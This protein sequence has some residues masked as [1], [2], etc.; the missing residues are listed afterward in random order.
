[1]PLKKYGSIK[2][3]RPDLLV[4]WNYQENSCS[5]DDI[6]IGNG[7]LKIDWKCHVCGFEW[8][9]T[10][11]NRAHLHSGCPECA[12]Q[13]I[14]IKN[15]NKNVSKDNN[16]KLLY[17]EIAAEWCIDKNEGIKPEHVAP[18]S[19][20][21][22]WWHCSVCGTE[23]QTSVTNRTGY[24]HVGCPKC[25]R[26]LHTSF[27]EQSLFYY[28]S[29]VYSDAVS[30]YDGIGMELDVFIPSIM[31]GVE[32]D[33][34]HWHSSKQSE[35][36]ENKKY[37]LC[38]DKNIELIR[39]REKKNNENCSKKNCDC[40]VQRLNNSDE[41]LEKTICEVLKILK[42][43]YRADVDLTRDRGI[44][45]NNYIV[46][47]KENS[48]YSKFPKIAAEWNDELNGEL[49]PSMVAAA[50]NTKVWWICPK[51][52]MAYKTSPADRTGTNK[53]GCPYCAGK[54]IAPGLNDLATKY[55]EIAAD[56]DFLKNKNLKPNEIAPNYIKKVWWKCSICGTEY[57]L[58]PNKRVSRQ[59]G[60]PKCAR[61]LKI[62]RSRMNSLDNGQNSLSARYP[63]I[64]EDWDYDE[65]D[66]SPDQITPGNDRKVYWKCHVCGHVWL[67]SPYSR[68]HLKSGCP[69]CANKRNGEKTHKKH[70][71]NG[72]NSLQTCRPDL[73]LDWNFSKNT[74]SPRN[75]SLGNNEKVMWK[76]HKCGNEW[77]TSVYNRA[78][79]NSQCPKC[80][81]NEM[82]LQK[83]KKMIDSGNTL[84]VK[85]PTIAA[86]WHPSRNGDLTPDKIA[87]HSHAKV[88]WKCPICGN[89]W[90]TSVCNRT[91]EKH[92]GCRKCSRRKSYVK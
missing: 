32:Y 88:W 21:K 24:K 37:K 44:I 68:I 4:D 70:L 67:A 29:K 87:P 61:L 60:C 56:W 30:G 38:K 42:K 50:T 59:Q 63:E 83:Q 75:I 39:V 73:M 33:G 65:N 79:L 69:Q 71:N 2:N 66:I 76:C 14:S 86:E 57:F 48:L 3:E 64:L 40:L 55:P 23:Y 16:L 19:N 26:R 15:R 20:Y 46:S 53:A 35:L 74:I 6:S 17:P 58:S 28:I 47:L 41:A 11:Y 5:P 12:K 82:V 13:K 72:K 78:H 31:T 45:A 22:A 81:K 9:A 8:K 85:F 51:C 18:Q 91:G 84:A 43:E 89:E 62:K 7:I 10:A 27:P 52:K 92:T 34:K 90:K 80:A 25:N 49:K 1:M 36:R 77:S 54:K